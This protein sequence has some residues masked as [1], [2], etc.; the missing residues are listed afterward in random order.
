MAIE[1]AQNWVKHIHGTP[2]LGKELLNV[3][4]GDWQTY[5]SIATREGYTFTKEELDSAWS[6]TF[7][8]PTSLDLDN[9]VGGTSNMTSWVAMGIRG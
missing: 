3:K 1:S 6:E 5:F 9:V 8:A 2:D 4:D 7:S